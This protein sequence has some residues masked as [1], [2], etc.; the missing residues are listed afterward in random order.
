MLKKKTILLGNLSSNLKSINMRKKKK[1]KARVKRPLDSY[2]E[3]YAFGTGIS[4]GNQIFDVASDALVGLTSSAVGDLVSTLQGNNNNPNL[5]SFTENTNPS[6]ANGGITEAN[7]E[8]EGGEVAETPDGQL[9]GFEGEDHEQGGIDVELPNSTKIFS[10][11]LKKAGDTMAKRKIKRER[12]LSKL[13]EYLAKN[14][15]SVFAKGSLE[16]TVETNEV[17]EQGDM[18]IQESMNVLKD[19]I[20][21]FMNGGKKQYPFGTPIE[22]LES[23]DDI[24]A[25]LRG[26]SQGQEFLNG[27][28][29]NK[30]LPTTVLD[31]V[32]TNQINDPNLSVSQNTLD[33]ETPNRT[34]LDTTPLDTIGPDET[35]P[36]AT[37]FPE[38]QNETPNQ[39]Y[40]NPFQDYNFTPGDITGAIGTGI[41]GFGPLASTVANRIGDKPNQNF[42]KDYGKQGLQNLQKTKGLVGRLKDEA[43]RDLS[44]KEASNRKRARGSARGLNTLRALDQTYD[45]QT[46]GAIGDVYANYAQQLSSILGQET[47]LLNQRDQVVGQGETQR[48]LADRKDRDQFFTNL[49][50][51]LSNLGTATQKAGKDLNVKQGD[52]D[53][54]KLLPALSQYGLSITQEGGEYFFIDQAGNKQKI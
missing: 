23:E 17:E 44:L 40:I 47:S 25:I 4:S 37:P 12:K 11:R 33:L 30:A 53:F 2:L 18:M 3:S 48:D 9:I 54:R 45:A 21:I 35:I 43:R 32:V 49:S 29:V 1:S 16:R 36:D 50:R 52:V 15:H 38:G 10:K 51:N 34:L 46:Q 6:F 22:G 13:E 28:L 31:Q 27:E 20:G 14:P 42:F 19:S 7:A 26:Q 39:E 8:V 41:S 5:F 24:A